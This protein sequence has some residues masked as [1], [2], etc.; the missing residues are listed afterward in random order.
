MVKKESLEKV[1]AGGTYKV[2]NQ[3]HNQKPLPPQT[4]VGEAE[5]WI[6]KPWSYRPLANNCETF[7]SKMRYGMDTGFSEQVLLPQQVINI[8]FSI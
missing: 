4:I 5:K 7:A 2:N 3:D 6:G 1:A 8:I